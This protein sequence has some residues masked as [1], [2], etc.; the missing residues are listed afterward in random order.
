VTLTLPQSPTSRVEAYAMLAHH[1]LSQVWYASDFQPRDEGDDIWG[2]CPSCCAPCGALLYL[3]RQGVL[4]P[5]LREWEEG[6]KSSTHV[7]G[8]LDREWLYRQWAGSPMQ[9]Q[10]GHRVEAG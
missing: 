5:L 6:M 10:C 1:A 8:K 4:E 7:N 3:D 9:E 2:C